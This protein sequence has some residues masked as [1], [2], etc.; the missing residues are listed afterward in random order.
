MP[1]LGYPAG[2]WRREGSPRIRSTWL[3]LAVLEE[4]W[5]HE[6]G[7]REWRR[8]SATVHYLNSKAKERAA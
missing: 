3:G 8:A 5:Q 1:D 6:D 7:R 2:G 4:F